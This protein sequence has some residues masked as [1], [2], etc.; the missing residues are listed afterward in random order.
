MGLDDEVAQ[1]LEPSIR[2]PEPERGDLAL[3]CFDA[4][5]LGKRKP[6]E[7]AQQIV[8]ALAKDTRFSRVEAAG[9]YVNVTIAPGKL[10]E[11]V[12]PVARSEAFGATQI[13]KDQTVVIDFSSPNI[14]KPLAFHHVRSTVI[15]AALGRIHA[16]HG[17]R[18][19]G[20]NYLGDWGKQFGL[21]A[22]G[23][24]RHGDPSLRS[25]A[26]HL[27]EVYVRANAEADVG[28][29]RARI[30]RPSEVRALRD[31]LVRARAETSAT[32]DERERKKL[33]KK[34]RSLE[35]RVRAIQGLS[36]GTD[37]LDGLDAFLARAE[38][39]GM[40]ARDELAGAEDRDREAR[41]YFKRLEEGDEEA[42]AEWKK[43]RETSIAEFERVYAR[44]GID[45]FAYEGESF[46]N[47]V[48]EATIARVAL[49]PGVK[50][51]EGALVVDMPNPEGEPPAILKTRDG[52]TLYLTRDVA[53]AIDRFERFAF[54]K[55]LYVV[56]ADQSLHFKQLFRT[57]T[58]M[59]YEWSSRCRHVEFGRVHGMSTRR[60]AVVFLDEVLDYAV[61]MAREECESSDKI[62]REHLEDTVEAIGIGAV[63]FGDLRNLRSSD[64]TFR[65]EDAV[66]LDGFSGPYVQYMHA[67]A[68][69]IVRKADGAPSTANLELLTTPEERSV[70]MA[71]ARYPDAMVA[72]LEALEP[73]I[74]TRA[75][76]D[77]A[78]ATAAWLTS[79]N[80][81][82]EKRVL[83]DDEGLRGARL[84]LVD[85][86]RNT[87]ATGLA[88]LGVRAPRAM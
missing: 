23:F 24:R 20:I 63:V 26:K 56:A 25:D 46:Y 31:E 3:P 83:V 29:R 17:Y 47:D 71:L 27:V 21:L 74:V 38:T 64:Y 80:Q 53:A 68:S 30:S 82:R 41:A 14:A 70:I 85:G 10:A 36:E 75:L 34:E 9:P 35:K 12:V 72:A 88:V 8:E 2:V 76:Y 39:D 16:A 67:R 13:G 49:T 62:D 37:P 7:A 81:E 48:L 19:V 44:M 60:G 51:S 69:S 59:G 50:E 55:S 54:E 5:R 42:I 65:W 28:G 15:G 57:L 77:L 86:V 4:A 40:K 73:S 45:F 87:L 11:A 32:A 1:K 18:V 66:R 61:Q 33:E 58:S 84:W 6:P 43:F 79:G 52:T 78:Q 22:T